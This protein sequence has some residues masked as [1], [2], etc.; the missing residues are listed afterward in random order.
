MLDLSQ[1][2]IGSDASLL[3]LSNNMSVCGAKVLYVSQVV[4]A[5]GTRIRDL[6]RATQAVF[7]YLI[8]SK[9]FIY[10]LVSLLAK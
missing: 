9:L 10:K 6:S 5:N 2:M 8:D 7:G 1:V 4:F 3:A